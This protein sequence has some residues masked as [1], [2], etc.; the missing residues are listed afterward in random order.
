MHIRCHSSYFVAAYKLNT[1]KRFVP[2]PGLAIFIIFFG[3]SLLE[4]FQTKNW[5]RVLFWL[6]VGFLFLALDNRR[7]KSN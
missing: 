5:L 4:A 1:M 2:G 3:V 6:A 7:R